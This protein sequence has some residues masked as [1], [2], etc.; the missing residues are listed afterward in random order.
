MRCFTAGLVPTMAHPTEEARKSLVGCVAL[1]AGVLA[2][3]GL[4]APA[5]AAAPTSSERGDAALAPGTIFVANAGEV[6]RGGGDRQRLG[7]RLSPGCHRQHPPGPRAYQRDNGPYGPHLRLLGRPLGSQ[8][9]Q[10]QRGRVQQS[11]HQ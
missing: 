7:H 2:S 1:L 9:Q 3:T 8:Q 5:G 11:R 6:R 4:S 10:R